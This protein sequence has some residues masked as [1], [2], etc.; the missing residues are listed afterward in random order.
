[1][2]RSRWRLE[3][4]EADQGT[5]ERKERKK[6]QDGRNLREGEKERN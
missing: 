5:E 2:A 1:M 4:T 3:Q 6:K